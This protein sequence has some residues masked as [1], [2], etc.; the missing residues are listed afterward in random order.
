MK[1]R[2]VELKRLVT[3]FN[4]VLVELQLAVTEG[5]IAEMTFKFT[6]QSVTTKKLIKLITEIEDRWGLKLRIVHT[7]QMS[8]MAKDWERSESRTRMALDQSREQQSLESSTRSEIAEPMS[9]RGRVEL[10]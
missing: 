1:K 4:Y 7:Y 5:S 10:S 2:G 8:W 9:L 3:V 6:N